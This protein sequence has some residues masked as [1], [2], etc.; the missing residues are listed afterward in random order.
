[1]NDYRD[2]LKFISR[3]ALAA[4]L[5]A[6]AFAVLLLGGCRSSVSTRERIE[7]GAVSSDAFN[8]VSVSAESDSAVSV[9]S[10]RELRRESVTESESG[11]VEI[12]RD[13]AGLPVSYRWTRRLDGRT[14]GASES[15]DSTRS[16]GSRSA[17]MAS[18]GSRHS[19]S[20]EKST[21]EL[22]E[23]RRGAAAYESEGRLICFI[24]SGV[25]LLLLVYV[26][27]VFRKIWKGME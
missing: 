15:A 13:S 6:C 22:K 20:S 23:S 7:S 19:E 17:A 2:D 12:V 18:K 26:A 3:W 24:G 1:M 14:E 27:Y 11:V 10:G 21:A 4:L 25:M 8:S 5:V 9:S 16:S